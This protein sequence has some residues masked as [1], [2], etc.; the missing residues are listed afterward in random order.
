MNL[1]INVA[2]FS[3]RFAVG[4]HSTTSDNL[5]T[6]EASGTSEVFRV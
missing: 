1:G 5:V 3:A 6:G 4:N 2:G